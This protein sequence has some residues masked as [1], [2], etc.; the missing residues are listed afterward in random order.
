MFFAAAKD[1]HPCGMRVLFLF[2][3]LC[4]M[5]QTEIAVHLT[6]GIQ[7]RHHDIRLDLLQQSLHTALIV[8]GID[9]VDL[10]CSERQIRPGS[11][12]KRLPQNSYHRSLRM[13]F[14]FHY[15]VG[16]VP[17]QYR[18]VAVAPV[19]IRRGNRALII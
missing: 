8:P 9:E 1:P 11:N 19:V 17:H 16:A 2:S 14:I 5:D 6:L 4:S 3:Q 12:G 18:A 10:P 7:Q 15:Q 13:I